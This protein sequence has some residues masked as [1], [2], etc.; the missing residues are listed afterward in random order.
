MCVKARGWWHEQ[1][2][3]PQ[4]ILG[5]HNRRLGPRPVDRVER[6][7]RRSPCRL[8]LAPQSHSLHRNRHLELEIVRMYAAVVETYDQSDDGRLRL[9]LAFRELNGDRIW[10]AIGRYV[11]PDRA[12]L[13]PRHARTGDLAGR[14][15]RPPD[16]HPSSVRTSS[17]TGTAPNLRAAVA[18]GNPNPCNCK[19][20]PKRGV[21]Q[22]GNSGPIRPKL[23]RPLAIPGVFLNMHAGSAEKESRSI[24]SARW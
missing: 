24:F 9:A 18:V 15:I 3:I 13:P 19:S 20:K 23:L 2:P 5:H 7:S 21:N 6:D 14:P 16:G 10:D 11:S 4:G 17:G 1:T 8:H 22:P 12:L